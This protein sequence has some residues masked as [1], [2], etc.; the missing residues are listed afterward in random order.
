[1]VHIACLPDGTVSLRTQI[2]DAQKIPP[3]FMAKILRR[4]VQAKLLHSSRG[5]SGGFSM[6]R[7]SAEITLLDIVEAID[8]PVRLTRCSS[9]PARCAFSCDCPGSLAWPQVQETLRS[10]LR[11][12][13]LEDL[14]SAPRRNGRVA[15]INGGSGGSGGSGG[16]GGTHRLTQEPEYQLDGVR[17]E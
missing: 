16:T 1:M 3:S 2:A 15:A 13:T 6:V 8:G 17:V 5:V 4:L 12:F 14:T 7:P 9:D 11:G 10:A